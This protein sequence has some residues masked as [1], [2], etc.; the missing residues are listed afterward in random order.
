MADELIWSCSVCEK[1]HRGLPAIAFEAPAHYHSI[2]VEERGERTKLDKDFCVI[3]DEAFYVRSVLVIPILGHE[4]TLE[5][6]VW[7]SLSETNFKRYQSTFSDH[8]QAKLG[9]MFSWFGSGLPLYDD[10]IGL[11]CN[12]VAQNDR[13]RPF[14]EFDPEQDHQLVLD[15]MRGISLERALEF[16]VLA[17]HKH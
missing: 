15:Q 2:S 3:D 5:W 9:P 6:G 8:D 11:R 13:K 4:E 12:V 10:T 17:L 16:A 1:I 14:I 7:S